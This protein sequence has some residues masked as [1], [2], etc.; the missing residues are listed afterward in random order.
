MSIVPLIAINAANAANASGAEAAKSIVARF[1]EAGAVGPG[2]AIAWTPE[3]KLQQAQFG[4]LIEN[5]ALVEMRPGTYFLNEE[6]LA[7]ATN[8]PVFFLVALAVFFALAGLAILMMP[9]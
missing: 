6:K 3:G 8:W 2:E 7:A 4:K 5:G 9:G 1:R